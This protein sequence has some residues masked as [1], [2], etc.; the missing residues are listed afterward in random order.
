MRQWLKTIRENSGLNTYDVARKADIS[1]GYYSMIE[2]GARG[3]K[4][5]VQT[6]KK[7]AEVLGFDWTMF[8]EDSEEV[9]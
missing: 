5:P 4:M 6:A 7:I 2:L 8:Y 3:A 9:G 1:Q